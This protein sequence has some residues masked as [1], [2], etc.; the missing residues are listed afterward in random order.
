M[1]APFVSSARL[2]P[3]LEVSHPETSL[4]SYVEAGNRQ[5]VIADPDGYVLRF[6]EDLGRRPI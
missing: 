4:T 6:Y 3:G 2:V 5:F 1:A